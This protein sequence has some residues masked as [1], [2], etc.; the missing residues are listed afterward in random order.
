MPIVNLLLGRWDVKLSFGGHIGD[1]LTFTKHP[2]L[3]QWALDHGAD[4][5]KNRDGGLYYPLERTVS[6]HDLDCAKVLISGGAH[7]KNAYALVIA[8][9]KGFNPLSSAL[10]AGAVPRDP[11]ARSGK[12]GTFGGGSSSVGSWFGCDFDGY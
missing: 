5:N 10:K 6:G 9:R 11:V 1:I 4:P 7:V 12:G 3:I 2:A 8:A